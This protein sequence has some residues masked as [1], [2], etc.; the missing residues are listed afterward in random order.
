M[1]IPLMLIEPDASSTRQNGALCPNSLA[2]GSFVCQF[3]K[4]RHIVVRSF[5][6]RNPS[7]SS[8]SVGSAIK[9]ETSPHLMARHCHQRGGLLQKQQ[10]RLNAPMGHGRYCCNDNR[11]WFP[12]ALSQARAHQVQGRDQTRDQV[13]VSSHVHMCHPLSE[14]KIVKLIFMA[15]A[16]KKGRQKIKNARS[17]VVVPK[18]SGDSFTR[19]MAM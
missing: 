13:C 12:C 11:I 9:S 4:S 16:K 19:P 6:E 3:H 7:S 1:S 10:C 8:V 17:G 5:F 2:P 14:K 15:E 18:D